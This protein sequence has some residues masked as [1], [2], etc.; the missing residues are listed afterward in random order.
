LDPSGIAQ[1][2]PDTGK[3]ALVGEAAQATLPAVTAA[4]TDGRSEQSQNL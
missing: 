3:H 1:Q 2:M 4:L